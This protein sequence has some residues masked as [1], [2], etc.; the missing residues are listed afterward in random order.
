MGT[1]FWP[2]LYNKSPALP[3][4]LGQNLVHNL[5]QNLGQRNIL[6]FKLISS[7]VGKGFFGVFLNRLYDFDLK[8]LQNSK[9]TNVQQIEHINWAEMFE[10]YKAWF[11]ETST[12][13]NFQN[14]SFMA[15]LSLNNITST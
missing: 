8:L 1:D 9:Y 5:G 6:S 2:P 13:D 14:R 11:S 10:C 7:P 4:Y 3:Q 12:E 15:A